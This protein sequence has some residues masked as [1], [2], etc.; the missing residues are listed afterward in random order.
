MTVQFHPR[1]G[2]RGIE[3]TDE[4]RN[5][6]GGCMHECKWGM[7]DGTVAVCYAKTL[8]EHGVAKAAYPHGFEHHYWRPE[9]LRE[10]AAGSEPLLIFCDSMSDLFA[11]NVPAEHVRAVL[12]AMRGAPQHAYQSLTKAAPQILK[13]V[14][15]LPLNLWVGVSSPPDW[16]L[17]RHLSRGQ[18][19]A[20]LKRSL[21]VLREV[22]ARTGNIVWMSA[23]P[24]SWDLTAVLGE[25]HPL[26]WIVIGAA[27][28]GRKTFQP[29]PDDVRN[30]L[31]VLDAT[32]TPVFFKGNIKPLF[33][34]NDL[35]SAEL[36][37]WREDFPATYRDGRPIP[38]VL[39]RQTLC[40]RH[41]WTRARGIDV[42]EPRLAR[43]PLVMAE[44]VPE[45]RES[46]S[47]TRGLVER[48]VSR[49][50]R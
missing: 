23:E 46:R 2:G 28:A 47:D 30:L 33:A 22:K 24:V 19:Q 26:D 18:Q 17:G 3:W 11:A 14:D 44:A 5:A 43:L 10:L 45:E 16:F 9:K 39:R 40:V 15:E 32:A 34:D 12:R 27:S 13:S 48:C 29:D 36:N 25:D 1:T 49:P 7:P 21:D 20:M 42:P 4:T 38:A 31:R 41:G 50:E 6:L 8:A 37:R 35:G